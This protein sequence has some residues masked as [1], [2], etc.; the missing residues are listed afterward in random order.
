[1]GCQM[2][3]PGNGGDRTCAA[4]QND[5]K[6]EG[7]VFVDWDKT[8]E[9]A[10][11]WLDFPAQGVAAMIPPAPDKVGLRNGGGCNEKANPGNVGGSM[12]VVAPGRLQ[13]P[14]FDRVFCP[15]K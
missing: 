7:C 8:L 15:S 6:K 1:A 5:V 14:R 10:T 2:T 12:A 3:W 11:V 4:R 13:R 9:Y